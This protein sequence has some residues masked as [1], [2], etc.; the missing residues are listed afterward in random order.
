MVSVRTLHAVVESCAVRIRVWSKQNK[1]RKAAFFF[2]EILVSYR[3]YAVDIFK[4]I[5]LVLA[6]VF[7]LTGK[8]K[9]VPFLSQKYFI[10]FKKRLLL[11][12]QQLDLSIMK[13]G[14]SLFKKHGVMGFLFF[15][16]HIFFCIHPVYPGTF[17]FFY[18][19]LNKRIV[20]YSNGK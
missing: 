9:Q 14:Y 2:H 15:H 3:H 17:H 18:P 13:T 6:V 10:H 4:D 20:F 1:I 12:G 7:I 8:K 19:C 5:I 16:P 11:S